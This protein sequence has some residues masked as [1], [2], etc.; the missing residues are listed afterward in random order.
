MYHKLFNAQTVAIETLESI[1]ADM[2]KAQQETEEM[3]IASDNPD[4]KLLDSGKQT[5]KGKVKGKTP[6]ACGRHPL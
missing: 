5:T 4:L 6:A 2:K 1:L 3:Y